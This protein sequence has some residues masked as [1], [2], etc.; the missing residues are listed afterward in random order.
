MMD[1]LEEDGKEY[2]FSVGFDEVW[3][4]IGP[5]KRYGDTPKL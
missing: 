4:D 3:K 5:K 2:L 1:Y